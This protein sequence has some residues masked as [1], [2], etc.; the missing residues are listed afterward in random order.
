ML[1][2]N[3]DDLYEYW[4]GNS[5]NGSLEVI[6]EHMKLWFFG[7]SPEF[8]QVQK[9]SINL[10]SQLGRNMNFWNSNEDPRGAVATII[11]LDQFSR[12]VFRGTAQA[13]QYDEQCADLI[14]EIL[15][16]GWFENYSPIE[17]FFLIVSLQHSEKLVNQELGVQ[18]AKKVGLNADENIIQY[19]AN[20]KGFPHEHYEVILQFGRFPHRNELLVR[21]NDHTNNYY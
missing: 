7:V 19:F 17:R 6:Q 9:D 8:D 5:I 18:N 1:L 10:I 20:L 16:K 11:V 15:A 14:N 12:S 4:F 13:F 2:Q 3:P 21:T